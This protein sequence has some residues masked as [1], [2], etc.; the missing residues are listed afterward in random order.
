MAKPELLFFPSP[1]MGHVAQMV[2]LAKV[3][4][5]REPKISITIIISKLPDS[6]DSVSGPFV[7]SLASTNQ[8]KRLHFFN[9][10]TANPSPDWST[11]TRG[12]YVNMLIRS[13][14]QHVHTFI[15]RKMEETNE[16][17]ISGIVVDMLCTSIME[18]GQHFGISSYVFLTSGAGFLGQMLYFQKLHDEENKDIS[19]FRN[20]NT[21]VFSPVFSKPVPPSVLPLVFVDKRMWLARFL[22]FAR[23]YRKA[24]AIIVNTFDELELYPLKAL[25]QDPMTPPVYPVGPILNQAPRGSEQA[26]DEILKWLDCQPEKSVVFI[27]FGSQGSIDEEQIQELAHGL[28]LS[29]HRFLW[30]LRKR[31]YGNRA[32]YPGEYENFKD[33]LPENFL[34]QTKEVGKIVGWVPQLDVL[35]HK[36]IGG[37]VS[38]CGWNSTLESIWNGVPIATWPLHAEQQLN[39]FQLVKEENLAVEI[40]L[41]YQEHRQEQGCALISA[42]EIERGLRRLMASDNEVRENVAKMSANARK[43]IEV[44]GSSYAN[45]RRLIEDMIN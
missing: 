4:I 15:K 27:C 17:R 16:S 44:G 5:N 31:S 3:I 19:E 42:E 40:S 8:E 20:S 28:E 37:F 30:A 7:D 38:H 21:D 26:R 14:K 39:S 9:L 33:V 23:G 25:A 32:G 18:V 1:S 41:D 2:E 34:D 24:R 11:Q 22:D 43:S 29:G 13:Q 35:A 12:Y 6:I 36:S 10:P 45:L